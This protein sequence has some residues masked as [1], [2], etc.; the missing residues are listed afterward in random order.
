MTVLSAHP[1][2]DGAGTRQHESERGRSDCVG[3]SE[4]RA[5]SRD[6]QRVEILHK[7]SH[8]VYRHENVVSVH[9]EGSYTVLL[10]ADGITLKFQTAWIWRLKCIPD[11]PAAAIRDGSE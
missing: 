1:R 8:C 4:R 5:M 11:P 2:N 9:E 3:D 6:T 7:D 10:K